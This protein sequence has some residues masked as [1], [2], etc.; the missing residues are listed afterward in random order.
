MQAIRV[1]SIHCSTNASAPLL[2]YSRAHQRL[3]L[4]TLD[5]RIR[6][7][8][9]RLTGADGGRQTVPGGG[10][11]VRQRLALRPAEAASSLGCSRDSSIKTSRLSCVGSGVAY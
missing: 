6:S 9:Y 7:A 5:L 3:D 1:T 8:S 11:R 4:R 10:S 2:W